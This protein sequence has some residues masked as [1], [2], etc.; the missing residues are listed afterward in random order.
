MT[1]RSDWAWLLAI[2]AAAAI[3][4]EALFRARPSG[5][6]WFAI[7]GGAWP[8]FIVPATISALY[9]LVVPRLAPIPF[10]RLGAPVRW[11][12]LAATLAAIALAGTAL[13]LALLT[14]T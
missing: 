4:I 9:L 8:V 2:N 13:A 6:P 12:T 3:L 5:A 7:L 11:L 14:F 10:D 1:R